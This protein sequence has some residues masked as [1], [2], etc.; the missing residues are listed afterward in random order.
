MAAEL[1]QTIELL[2]ALG[3]PAPY[4]FAYP[5]GETQIGKGKESYVGLVAERFLAARGVQA[6]VAD[7]LRDPLSLVPACDGAKGTDELIALVEQAAAQ[8]GWLVLLFHGVGGDHLPVE[9][10]AHDALATHLARS[11]GRIWTERFGTVAAHV[12]AWRA[13]ASQELQ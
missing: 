6:T 4:S 2:A 7:P 3:A 12:Q 10:A 9:R 11:A 5:C 8:E 1:D 13:L